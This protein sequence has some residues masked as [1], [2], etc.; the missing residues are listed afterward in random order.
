MLMIRTLVVVV[1]AAFATACSSAPTPRQLARE[2][3]TAMGGMDKLQ[4]I[5]TIAM[6]G[7][8]GTRARM[9]QSKQVSD[10]DSAGQL[11]NVVEVADLANGRASIDYE[12]ATPSGFT[13]HRHEVL[14]RRGGSSGQPIG[15][16]YVGTRP[17]VAT[18]PGGLFSWGTQNSPEWLLRRNVVTIVLAAAESASDSQPAE[19][20]AFEGKMYKHGMLETSAGEDIGLYFDPQSKRLAAFEVTDTETMLGDVPAQ[21]VL[22]DYKAVDGVVLP[23]RTTIRKGGKEYSDVQYSSILIND[24]SAEEVFAIPEAATKDA[25]LAAAGDYTPLKLTKV[26]EGVYHAQAY[27]HHS[28]IVEFPSWLAVVEAPYTETQSKVLARLIQQQL[29]KPIQYAAVTHHHY[30]HT[31][32]VRGIAALGAMVLVEKNHEPALRELLDAPH[33]HPLDELESR[34]RAKP[35]QKTGSLDVYEGKKVI[36]EGGQSLE[37]YAIA[38]SPH[39][40]PMVVA[41]VPGAR[42]LFNSDLFFPGTGAGGPE[43]EHLL[44]SIKK[45]NLPVDTMVGG[46]GGVGPFAE[47]LKAATP[48]SH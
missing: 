45:L 6:K 4:A 37:L 5:R 8:A 36:T 47:L 11:K 29:K 16:E 32:G 34:R 13:Q 12:L 28:L 40:E 18:S 26:A 15:I 35:P 48:A 33:T 7:G 20:K 23:H 9:G 31:G 10:P 14:T 27:S 41:Y 19:D 38:G 46:H 17:V 39:V 25:D 44:A 2:A 21:Y 43:A 3:V 30:D 42:V 24:R 1:I 22:G